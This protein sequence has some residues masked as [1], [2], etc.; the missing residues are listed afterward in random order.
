[1]P[2][3]R[4][5]FANLLKG[6]KKRKLEAEERAKAEEEYWQNI[7]EDAYKKPIYK[8]WVPPPPP[9]GGEGSPFQNFENLT[10]D[11]VLGGQ[12]TI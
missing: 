1:M 12:K 2:N 4:K 8:I 7:L 11:L 5:S 6:N 9:I 3:R 10:S